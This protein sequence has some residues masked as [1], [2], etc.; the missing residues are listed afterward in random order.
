MAEENMRIRRC[1]K[2]TN[3]CPLNAPKCKTGAAIAEKE[4][5]WEPIPEEEKKGLLQKIFHRG[6]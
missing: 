5:I 6:Y 4:G 3:T 2:C 1:P